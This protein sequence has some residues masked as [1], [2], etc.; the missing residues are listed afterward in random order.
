[1]SKKRKVRADRIIIIVLASILVVG[2]L[3]FG[4]SKLLGL[5]FSNP[6]NNN[7]TDKPIVNPEPIE[8]SDGVKVTLASP[9]SY[10]VYISDNPEIDFNFIIAE[11]KFVGNEAISFDLGNLR[12]SEK[13]YL[14]DVS[15]YLNKLN[16]NG[17]KAEKLN[18]VSSV[19][20]SEK[21]YTCKIF[22]PFKTNSYSLRIL[23]SADATMIEF[24]LDKNKQDISSIKFDTDQQIVVGDTNVTVLSSYVERN[25]LHNGEPYSVPSSI[26]V[27]TFKINVSKVEGNVMISDA[28]FIK[29]NSDTEYTCLSADYE[30]E[31]VS[32]CIG[33]KLVEGENGALFFEIM[34]G[35]AEPNYSGA[36]MLKFSNNLNEWVKVPTVLE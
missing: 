23:N 36:L 34:D 12:T 30:A 28:R 15:K 20:S 22:V 32:N 21:E 4:I 26:N 8:T 3:G 17:Y 16:E 1:M 11:L 6:S 27:Y 35:S 10:T 29:D 31:K 14:N 24:D 33:K 19:V 5:I 18:V 25:M 9:D 2:L 7:P 13:I